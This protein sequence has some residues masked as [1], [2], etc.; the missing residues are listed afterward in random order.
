MIFMCT[1]KRVGKMSNGR[2][3]FRRSQSVPKQFK[4]NM[5]RQRS[6]SRERRVRFDRN[7]RFNDNGRQYRKEQRFGRNSRY[8]RRQQQQYQQSRR[9]GPSTGV[10][11]KLVL[12]TMVQQNR[13]H[14]YTELAAGDVRNEADRRALF[15]LAQEIKN[16]VIQGAGTL[17]AS[18]DTVDYH[19]QFQPRS[20]IL[21][22]TFSTGGQ[23]EA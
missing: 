11:R 17:S 15:V 14:Y 7:T 5:Q 1:N 9:N 6:R 21:S 16:A 10:G 20:V 19:V 4:P 3:N 18:E 12:R 8:Q 2:G 13:Y 22:G 23:S